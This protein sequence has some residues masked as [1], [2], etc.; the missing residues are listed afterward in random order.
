MNRL[1]EIINA[2]KKP[3]VFASKNQFAN[4]DTVKGLGY[5]IDKLAKEALTFAIE[6]PDRIILEH[7]ISMFEQFESLDTDLKKRRII[8]TRRKGNWTTLP[9]LVRGVAFVNS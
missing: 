5:H 1:P 8:T 3:L 6:K 2:I 7:I 9:S 4:L